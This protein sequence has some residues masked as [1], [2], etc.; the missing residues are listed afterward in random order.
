[1]RLFIERQRGR[2]TEVDVPDGASATLAAML[3][4]DAL[5][6]GPFDGPWRIGIGVRELGRHADIA[7]LHVDQTVGDLTDPHVFLTIEPEGVAKWN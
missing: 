2:H 7:F 5:D 4:A 6:Y 3:M 1:M